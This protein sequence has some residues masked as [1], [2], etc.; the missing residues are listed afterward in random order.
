[1]SIIDDVEG[2]IRMVMK[3][4]LEN[5]MDPLPMLGFCRGEVEMGV[6]SVAMPDEAEE[7][8]KVYEHLASFMSIYGATEA[9]FVADTAVSPK[10]EP[11]EDPEHRTALWFLRLPTARRWLQFY[12][13]DEQGL[14]EFDEPSD[15]G[16]SQE[17]VA[18]YLSAGLGWAPQQ[19]MLRQAGP[20]WLRSK[21]TG[22]VLLHDAA[23]T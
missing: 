11:N 12:R 13:T 22:T 15:E 9:V 6:V 18:T 7:R 21:V 16:M 17:V 23:I 8:F 5:G 3:R 19:L 2:R 1:M 20:A 4:F 14:V 10:E